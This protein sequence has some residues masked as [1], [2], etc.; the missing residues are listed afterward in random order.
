MSSSGGNADIALVVGF[1]AGLF[2]FFKGFRVYREYRVL[3]DTPEMPIRSIPMGLVEIHGK[4][5]GDQLVSSPVT[6]T[7]SLFY[8]VDIE[9][10]QRNP[11]GG[12]SWYHAA[13]D[14]NG[15]LFY[16]EDATGKVLVDARGAELD[17]IRGGYR[18]TGSATGT[19]WRCSLRGEGDP[20][21]TTG[22]EVTDY[23]L[24]TYAESVIAERRGA[25]LGGKILSKMTRSYTGPYRLAEY[26]ILPGHWYD[27]TGTCMENPNPKDEHDRN[28]IVKGEKRTDIPDLLAERTR[29]SSAPCATGRP[30]TFSAASPWRLF[31]WQS[32]WPKFGWL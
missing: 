15:V 17:L 13:T 30:S 21:L 25:S 3:A 24:T 14:T 8:K 20:T 27:L 23:S 1:G 31:A 18:E 12:G 7:P 28:M 32:C 11:K 4:A 10:Y 26:C 22:S 16:V 29:D 2:F 6:N 19:S 9:V 5:G